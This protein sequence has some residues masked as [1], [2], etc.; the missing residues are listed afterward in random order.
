MVQ[1]PGKRNR[2]VPMLIPPESKSSMDALVKNRSVVGIPQ[3]NPY[4]FASDSKSGHI[5]GGHVLK[6]VALASQVE[7]PSRIST[8]NL[9]KYCATVT[10][11]NL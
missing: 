9:R 2:R 7:Q 10:Q 6:Q 11:V 1:L 3:E 4:F 8:T 5:D